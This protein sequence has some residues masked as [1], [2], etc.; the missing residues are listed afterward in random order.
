MLYGLS[1]FFVINLFYFVLGVKVGIQRLT[2]PKKDKLMPLAD[3]ELKDTKAK[4]TSKTFGTGVEV[5]VG[6][7]ML[8]A[9]S[10]SA[11]GIPLG[12]LYLLKTPMTQ[13]NL[14][15]LKMFSVSSN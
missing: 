5:S 12:Q 14:L 15:N 1:R 4:M 8:C 3:F 9:S 10:H 11:P 13:E 7:L 2:G 6:G